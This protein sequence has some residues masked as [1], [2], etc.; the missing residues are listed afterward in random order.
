MSQ[1]APAQ[2]AS[3][4]VVSAAS[5]LC[6]SAVTR[7][8]Y[9]WRSACL[10]SGTHGRMKPEQVT[11]M[12]KNCTVAVFSTLL[13]I[14]FP[15]YKSNRG[16]CLPAGGILL[17]ERVDSHTL[18]C[19]HAQ[20]HKIGYCLIRHYDCANSARHSALFCCGVLLKHYRYLVRKVSGCRLG[21]QA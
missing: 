18:A 7:Q 10:H 15:G 19:T 16:G 14:V 13:V 2:P 1:E 17:H 5:A 8:L 6:S 11:P 20:A 4:H 21:T 3:R 9:W 12:A